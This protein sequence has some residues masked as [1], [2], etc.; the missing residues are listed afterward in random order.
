MSKPTFKSTLVQA[1]AACVLTFAAAGSAAASVPVS[2]APLFLPTPVDPNIMFIIDDSGSMHWEV[3]P[4]EYLGTAY[5]VFPR[6]DG[7]YGAGDYANNVVS[8]RDAAPAAA[9]EQAY[10]AAMRSPEVNKSYYNPAITY[11]PWVR[12]DG[13]LFPNSNPTAA[14]HHPIRNTGTRNLTVNETANV[15]WR[16]CTAGATG[17]SSCATTNESRT[18]YPAVY[19]QY[20]GGNRFDR[21]SYTRV[22]IRSTIASYS[23]GGRENRSDCVGGVCTY[24]QEIQNFANWYTYYRSRMLASQAAIGRAFVNQSEKM[25]VGFGSL[26]AANSNVDGVN[27]RAIIRGVRQF[28]GVN[29]TNFYQSLYEG[30]WPPANTPLRRALD[31]AGQY[32][33]RSDNRGPWGAVPGTDD[34]SPH[35][36]CRQS[37]TILMTD[38]YW[39]DA[40]APTA[41]ARANVD[42]T[43][44]P[45]ITGPAGQ[46]YTYQ[47]VTPFTDAHADTVA[48]VAMYYWK[49]DLRPDLE[50]RVPA[51]PFN[52]AFW[53]HMVTFGVGLGVTGSID[54]DLAFSAIGASPP[55]NITWPNPTASNAAKLD[56]L[57]HA[58]VNSRGGFFSAADPE[59]FANELAGVIQTIVARTLASG[60]TAASAARR[61]GEFL[62]YVPDFD[63]TDWTGDLKAYRLQS[64]GQLG[65]LAWSAADLLA[66]GSPVSLGARRVFATV[67]SGSNFSIVPLASAVAQLGIGAG[68]LADLGPA[69]T[70]ADIVNYLRGDHSR[71]IRNGGTLRDRAKRLG[72][73]INSQPEV[74]TSATFGYEQLPDA[75]GGGT[76]PGSYAEFLE[77]KRDRRPVVFVATN[78]GMLHAFDGRP[79]GGGELFAIIPNSALPFVKELP[80]QNYQRRFLFDGSPVQADVRLGGQ[81]R[82]VLLAPAGLGGRSVTLLDVTDPQTSFGTDNFLWEFQHPG[83]GLTISKPSAVRLQGGRWVALF[84]NGLNSPGGSGT[85]PHKASL[86][87]VDLAN[88]SNF[89]RIQAGNDGTALNPNGMTAVVGVDTDFDGGV[90][91]IYGADYRGHVWRFDVDASGNIGPAKLLFRAV[92]AANQRQHI[93]GELDVSLHHI[94]GQMVYFGTGRFLAEGDNLVTVGSQVQTFYGIWDDDAAVNGRSELQQQRIEAEVNLSSGVGR[95]LTNNAVDWSTQKGWYLD[96][97]VGTT[98]TRGERVIG[99]PQVFQGLVLFTTY[100]P[101]GNPCIS[102][103]INRLYLL[104]ALTGAR[105]LNLGAECPDCGGVTLQEGAPVVD[106]PVVV[107]PPSPIC[108]PGIDPDCEERYVDPDGEPCN[109]AI[110]PGCELMPAPGEGCVSALGFVLNSGLNNRLLLQCG[111]QAWR[112]IE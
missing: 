87:V 73:I 17:V 38:G 103:G 95:R 98:P 64:D 41:G 105:N 14:R 101:L 19:F 48:D 74:L 13:T 76:G 15:A 8:F 9:A 21:A 23:G 108:R 104:N 81:W 50:N 60:G 65:A 89:Q 37:Y 34:P 18:F 54:P 20:N 40:A 85:D 22:E 45:T 62:V 110:N 79:N 56:D 49:R 107:T 93:T 58:G 28:E 1:A 112:Q 111:R 96:L 92:D 31:D 42:G 32:F 30:V 47:A 109:P 53:Q 24:A 57:L 2:D 55:I 66:S 90:D 75:D 88:A 71:E 99:Q 69:I 11:R 3:T 72:D 51:S 91:T 82:T 44:G 59:T 94:R 27:S 80:K 97:R 77:F 78:N 68:D 43:A 61:E 4:D 12:A 83:L 7:N 67:P 29:R 33:S 106:P 70:S 5:Y 46:T 36:E 84:G 63:T 6:A 86:F 26:N 52:P 35:I 102:G 10:V 100:E 16:R 39:N 25:R